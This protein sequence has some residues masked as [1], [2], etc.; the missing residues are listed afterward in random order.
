MVGRRAGVGWPVV[1]LAAV[2]TVLLVVVTALFGRWQRRALEHRAAFSVPSPPDLLRR[3]NAHE[4]GPPG[5]RLPAA[6]AV[7]ADPRL[8]PLRQAALS[9]RRATGPHRLVI[10]QVC[11][12]PDVP[13]FFAAL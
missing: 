5:G 8:E 4:G 9:W 12:V 2:L 3:G 7:A 11:L 13:S 1:F 10:D 6:P